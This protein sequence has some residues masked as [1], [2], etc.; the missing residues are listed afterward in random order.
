MNI[1]GGMHLP[2]ADSARLIIGTWWLVVLVVV[3][4]YCGNLVAF[5][6]FPKID[7]AITSVE[8][9]I[10]NKETVSWS[11]KR[12]TYLEYHLKVAHYGTLDYFIICNKYTFLD[13]RSAKISRF[14]AWS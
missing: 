5:L 4:T 1:L 6:T 11:I 12:G 8:Q 13:N 2:E 9:L 7:I 3:T 14:K 10:K